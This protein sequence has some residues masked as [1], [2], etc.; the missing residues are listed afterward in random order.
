MTTQNIAL[1]KNLSKA[2]IKPE[3]VVIQ[4]YL[5]LEPKPK[6]TPR[7]INRIFPYSSEEVFKMVAYGAYIGWCLNPQENL[8]GRGI[9]NTTKLQVFGLD[10]DCCKEK[11]HLT[12]EEI[13]VAKIK[14]I[15]KIENLKFRPTGI[16]ESKNGFQ[17]YW[18]FKNPLKLKT[19]KDR[20]EAEVFYLR[21]RDGFQLKTGLI[22]EGDGICRVLRV[23]GTLHQKNPDD[24]FEVKESG[25]SGELVDFEAFCKEYLP[26]QTK[27]E[28]QVKTKTSEPE[29]KLVRDKDSIYDYPVK[30]TLEKLSGSELVKGEVYTFKE[31]SNGTLQVLINGEFHSCWL[32]LKGNTI[33]A[34]S[35]EGSP[36]NVVGWIKYLNPEKKEEEIR[37]ILDKLLKPEKKEE[38]KFDFITLDQLYQLK[39]DPEYFLIDKILGDTG[40]TLFV[41]E[42][43]CGKSYLSLEIARSL[44]TGEKFLGQF[45]VKK[46]GRIL[47][48]DKE[49]GLK[50]IQK[51]FKYLNCPD[52]SDIVFLN[53]P[54]RFNPALD[55]HIDKIKQFVEA[56]KISLIIVD[57]LVDFFIGSENSAE[58][59]SKTYEQFRKISST[60]AWLMIHH[61]SKPGLVSRTIGQLTRGSG[62]ILSQAD[63]HFSI[64]LIKGS[65]I[66]TCEQGKSRD[67]ELLPKFELEFKSSKD[68]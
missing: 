37:L 6:F 47:I 8:K 25:G 45:E 67:F 36:V 20:E 16:I 2:G 35:A 26:Q 59:T 49:N 9:D 39:F 30:E 28:P 58:D 14:L 40:F 42:P 41:G 64:E 63:S 5:D 11:D 54:E 15:E 10:C 56:Q 52:T 44:V 1:F 4:T 62:N 33:G 17:P 60:C 68:F 66:H 18:I 24:T 48:L 19:I 50:R 61:Q 38:I 34:R 53:S 43:G 3:T 65:N 13:L 29:F 55:S 22:S 23:P 32:D 57:S 21:L 31:N 51:R 7:G 46:Q 27:I 12:Q